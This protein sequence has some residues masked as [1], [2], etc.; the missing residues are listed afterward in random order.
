MAVKDQ[1]RAAARSTQRVTEDAVSLSGLAPRL[2]CCPRV[3][4][5]RVLRLHMVERCQAT[6]ASCTDG[7][8]T[9]KAR[10]VDGMFVHPTLDLAGAQ[11]TAGTQ[12]TSTN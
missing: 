3:K 1:I 11:A 6:V 2:F 10:E 4:L 9:A 5:S 7:L 12:R 8:S